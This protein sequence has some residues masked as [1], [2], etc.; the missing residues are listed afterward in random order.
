MN[1]IAMLL[2]HPR[3]LREDTPVPAKNVKDVMVTFN[4]PGL[5][6]RLDALCDSKHLKRSHVIMIAL[7]RY[8]AALNASAAEP[9]PAPQTGRV[10]QALAPRRVR[11]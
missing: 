8:L 9:D 1:A 3:K 6:R 11:A 7:E 10:Q 2:A 4:P 5:L